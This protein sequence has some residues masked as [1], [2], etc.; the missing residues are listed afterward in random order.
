[1]RAVWSPAIVE[2]QARAAEDSVHGAH[3][4]HAL[5]LVASSPNSLCSLPSRVHGAIRR[6]SFFTELDDD[7]EEQGYAAEPLQQL[8]G[9]IN[10]IMFMLE[11]L[12]HIKEFEA[13]IPSS[14]QSPWCG[15]SDHFSVD[16]QEAIARALA[17]AHTAWDTL[18]RSKRRVWKGSLV[19]R[20]FSIEAMEDTELV[21][22][23][24]SKSDYK[25]LFSALAPGMTAKRMVSM[26]DEDDI[27]RAD[28]FTVAIYARN[29]LEMFAPK[30][31][32]QWM[33]S[34]GL[35]RS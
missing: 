9:G 2:L 4:A 20:A 34:N 30:A 15:D 8:Q 21:A 6:S 3:S 16:N 24:M 22:G 11:V 14:R 28:I 17:N 5:C 31:Y 32:L 10:H 12:S 7:E 27:K 25:L 13:A 1:M 18:S 29:W 35:S 26:M 33:H 19:G 23:I